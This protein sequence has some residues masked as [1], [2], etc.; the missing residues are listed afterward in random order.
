[1]S[2]AVAGGVAEA[3]R[4]YQTKK[5]KLPLS[6]SHS[7]DDQ[8]WLQTPKTLMAFYRDAKAACYQFIDPGKRSSALESSAVA[9]SQMRAIR[10]NEPLTAS[11]QDA[12]RQAPS[13]YEPPF[14]SVR[15]QPDVDSS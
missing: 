12:G 4:L 9:N 11:A 8:S 5:L 10:C 2:I 3:M 6:H 13:N 14:D 15:L 7:K 1:M